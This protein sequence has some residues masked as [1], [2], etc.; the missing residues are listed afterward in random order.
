MTL[1]LLEIECEKG[2]QILRGIGKFA[3]TQTDLLS[4]WKQGKIELQL[5]RKI[6][7]VAEVNMVAEICTGRDRKPIRFQTDFLFAMLV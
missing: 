3:R 1:I 5:I 4:G 2:S 6:I 7:Q